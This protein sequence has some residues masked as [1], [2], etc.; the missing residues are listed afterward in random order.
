MMLPKPKKKPKRQISNKHS[1]ACRKYKEWFLATYGY[2]F[3]ERCANKSP[4]A[5]DSHHVISAGSAPQHHH[6][7]DFRNLILLCRDCHNE[8]E[9]HPEQNQKLIIQRKLWELFDTVETRKAQE[10]AKRRKEEIARKNAISKLM[11]IDCQLNNLNPPH[12]VI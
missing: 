5:W 3:C 8:V 7:H 9:W 4:V 1:R 10:T 2:A 6:L 12:Y 11:D